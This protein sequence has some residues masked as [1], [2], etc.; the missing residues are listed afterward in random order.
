MPEGRLEGNKNGIET[1][2]TIEGKL[3][4]MLRVARRDVAM[5]EAALKAVQAN[6]EFVE[7]FNQVY[8]LVRRY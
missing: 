1:T 8:N 6:P 4:E 7:M 2:Q 5:I 3:T